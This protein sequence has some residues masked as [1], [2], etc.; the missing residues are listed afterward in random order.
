MKKYVKWILV[1]LTV[2]VMAFIFVMS[3]QNASDSTGESRGIG[4]IIGQIL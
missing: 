1:V 3:S 2:V 4:M